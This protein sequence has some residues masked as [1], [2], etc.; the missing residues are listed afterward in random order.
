MRLRFQRPLPRGAEREKAQTAPMKRKK[1]QSR[2]R[3]TDTVFPLP[4]LAPE[5]T[6]VTFRILC[7]RSR[8]E[9]AWWLG[10]PMPAPRT[11]TCIA[12]ASPSTD[13]RELLLSALVWGA[14]TQ[15]WSTPSAGACLR[16]W[17]R[18]SWE[19]RLGACL[20]SPTTS[21]LAASYPQAA[22]GPRVSC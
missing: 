13:D 15:S 1:R 11:H 17:D 19:G 18:G 9:C 3:V 2:N 14:G 20:A 10:R 6:R 22:E 12:S 7:G 5:G 4:H 8:K 21:G 16:G